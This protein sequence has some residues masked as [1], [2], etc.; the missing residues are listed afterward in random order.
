MPLIFILFP[1][2]ETLRNTK[3]F[4]SVLIFGAGPFGSLFQC[5]Y[6]LLGV[7]SFDKICQ[8]GGWVLVWIHIVHWRHVISWLVLLALI[9]STLVMFQILLISSLVKLVK[10]FLRSK[11]MFTAWYVPC[12]LSPKVKWH[13]SYVPTCYDHHFSCSV[14]GKCFISIMGKSELMEQLAGVE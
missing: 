13:T 3:V 4:I 9:Y 1:C 2:K 10:I 8:A 5:W 11:F 6:L 12:L 14:L 7:V